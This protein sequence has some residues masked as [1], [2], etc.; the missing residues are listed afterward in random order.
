M[1]SAVFV[2]TKSENQYY[3]GMES[4]KSCTFHLLVHRLKSTSYLVLCNLWKL[5]DPETNEK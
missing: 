5:A 4:S 1:V 3:R 2:G